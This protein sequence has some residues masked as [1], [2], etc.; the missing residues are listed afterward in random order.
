MRPMEILTTPAARAAFTPR[1][2][3]YALEDYAANGP[4][5]TTGNGRTA[6]YEFPEGLL[7]VVE[8]DCLLAL[9]T[10]EDAFRAYAGRAGGIVHAFSITLQLG[11]IGQPEAVASVHFEVHWVL[12]VAV[13]CKRADGFE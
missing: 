7:T 1:Q 6:I 9:C 13:P 5:S 2:L 8:E 11:R 4:A 3:S 10:A 12:V